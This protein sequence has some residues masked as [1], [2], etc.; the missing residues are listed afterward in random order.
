MR[1]SCAHRLPWA[2]NAGEDDFAEEVRAPVPVVLDLWA[3]WCQPCRMVS[4]LLD[5]LAVD[6]AG[7]VKVVR[8][9]VDDAPGLA[10]RFNALSIPTMVVLRDGEE[11][12]RIVGADP[13]LADR[14]APHLGGR[15]PD[16]GF[17]ANPAGCGTGREVSIGSRAWRSRRGSAGW[18]SAR[19]SSPGPA[20]GRSSPR[21]SPRPP[22][23]CRT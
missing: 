14:I 16:A 3:P 12:D 19:S 8:V 21:A 23:T 7:E 22:A 11:V 18:C 6:H 5:R 2:V 4:P 20:S 13:R 1:Q 17:A 9:N 10:Q 15:P